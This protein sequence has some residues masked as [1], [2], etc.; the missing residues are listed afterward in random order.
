M[1]KNLLIISLLI[2]GGCSTTAS[3]IGTVQKTATGDEYS[4]KDTKQGFMVAG[5]HNEY[6]FVR[7]SR[8]GFTSC[9]QLINNA[10]RSYAETKN[11][12]IILPKWDEI[13]IIDHGRDIITAVMHV[14]CQYE[15]KFTE[16]QSDIVEKINELKFLYDF[17][18]LTKEE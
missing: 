15:Y 17:G 14:N 2:I 1:K 11:K 13:E 4:I 3:H 10:A 18:A 6:Q 7:N 8:K 9:M 16:D 12:D 5:H